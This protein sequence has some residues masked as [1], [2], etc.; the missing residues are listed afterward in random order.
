MI[1]SAAAALALVALPAHAAEMRSIDV[2]Y[3][4]GHYTLVSEV[5]FDAGIDAIYDVFSRWDLSEQFSSAVVEARDVE[6]DEQ[7][8]PGFVVVNRGCVLFFCKTLR[9]EG[10][11]ERVPNA[12]LRSFADPERSDFTVSNEVW[13]FEQAD[14]GTVVKYTLYMKPAFWVPPAIGPYMIQRK[15]KKDGGKALD[16]IEAIAQDVEQADDIAP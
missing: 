1:R 14:D 13:E 6:A 3:E 15:L 8:R 9:R 10:Y 4:D 5:W 7:G 11:V 16:R 12:V 2:N